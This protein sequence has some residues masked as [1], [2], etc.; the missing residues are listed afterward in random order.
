ME[1]INYV[2]IAA[3]AAGAA[4][5]VAGVVKHAGGKGNCCGGGIIDTGDKKTLEGSA[6]G[7]YV[8]HIEGMRCENCKRTVE[9]RLDRFEAW[10]ARW[11]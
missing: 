6:L 2:L 3:I 1:W 4:G 11:I 8:L 5:G 9:R 7:K 10:S